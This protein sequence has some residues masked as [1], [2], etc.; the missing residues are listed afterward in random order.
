M[1]EEYVG[2]GPPGVRYPYCLLIH[3]VKQTPMGTDITIVLDDDGF[4]DALMVSFPPE[5]A[6][7]RSKYI[8]VVDPGP[9]AIRSCS[10]VV[11]PGHPILAIRPVHEDGDAIAEL[12]CMYRIA[13]NDFIDDVA[14]QRRVSELV[15]TVEEAEVHLTD[16]EDFESRIIHKGEVFNCCLCGVI[17]PEDKGY[18]FKQLGGDQVRALRLMSDVAN[19]FPF[20]C[21]GCF[22]KKVGVTQGAIG[23]A[24]FFQGILSMCLRVAIRGYCGA[25]IARYF[26]DVRGTDA[27]MF[28][29]F[30]GSFVNFEEVP[31]LILRIARHPL[32]MMVLF[33]MP[34]AFGAGFLMKPELVQPYTEDPSLIFGENTRFFSLQLALL[35]VKGSAAGLV[36][37][38]MLGTISPTPDKHQAPPPTE[39][40]QA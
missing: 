22:R 38:L 14:P 28:G 16:Q 29:A 27:V 7:W 36:L 2:F 5:D 40:S 18:H 15:G 26:F 1:S 13:Q 10:V 35:S 25:W 6:E 33:L 19:E 23:S 37:G 17:V 24:T 34:V 8:T 30:L 20:V 3:G 39:D 4:V 32:V 9:P 21:L 31:G 11:P 12:C